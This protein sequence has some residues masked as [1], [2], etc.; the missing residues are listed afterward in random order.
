MSYYR[1]IQGVRYE[2]SLLDNAE[3]Y[4]TNSSGAPLSLEAIQTLYELAKDGRR[5]TE[6]EQ[7]TLLY[8]QDQYELSDEAKVWLNG[9][10][11]PVTSLDT[12]I[13]NVLLGEFGLKNIQWDIDAKEV[14]RQEQLF[15]QL[16]FEKVLKGA[17]QAFAYTGRGYLNL[18][19]FLSIN[20]DILE[21]IDLGTLYLYPLDFDQNDPDTNLA[22]ETP[23]FL[24]I[25]NVSQSWIFALEIPEIPHHK[26]LSFIRRDTTTAF[27][28][29][30]SFFSQQYTDKETVK[31]TIRTLL[32]YPRMDWDFDIEEAKRQEIEYKNEQGWIAAMYLVLR[33]GVY[34]GESSISLYDHVLMEEWFRSFNDYR[35]KVQSYLEK[36]TISL[37]PEAYPEEFNQFLTEYNRLY[38]DEFWYFLL[39]IPHKPD[40]RVLLSKNRQTDGRD[41]TWNDVYIVDTRP[42]DE[43]VEGIFMDE[44]HIPE[45]KWHIDLDIFDQQRDAFGPN[46]RGIK[47]VLRQTLNTILQDY[48][49]SESPFQLVSEVHF[50]DYDPES[51]D[52]IQAYRSAISEK[53]RE[54]LNQGVLYLIPEEVFTVGPDDLENIYPPE[55]GETLE[56]YWLF[57][58]QLPTLS[59]HI[60]WVIIPRWPDY[61]EEGMQPY[62]YGFN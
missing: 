18:F 48:T 34:N 24:T 17:I 50:D 62:V 1:V 53:I 58:L 47:S 28:Y 52:S 7:R 36:A 60:F 42:E 16:S 2:R 51:F 5:I 6:T 45:L 14:N 29:S 22:F 43:Q 31:Y 37:V 11:L 57:Q 8:I 55:D 59:D 54:Y 23:K 39:T 13:K 38:F 27:G 35:P 46:W 25:R 15:P 56:S 33:S 21:L 41:D 10:E 12:R 4:K 3:E 9:E 32:K 26:F 30:T 19:Q 40:W 61:E 20:Q 44:F 49:T